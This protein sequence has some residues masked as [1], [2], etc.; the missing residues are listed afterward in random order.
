MLVDQF[1]QEVK[2]QSMMRH[3]NVME[4]YGVFDD[5]ENVY[6]VLEFMKN[7]SLYS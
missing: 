5:R 7:G 4:L 1:L 2:I 3:Q 6:M